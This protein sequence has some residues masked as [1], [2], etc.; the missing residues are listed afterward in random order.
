[1]RDLELLVTL[2]PSFPH[3]PKFARDPRLSGIRLN[4]AMTDSDELI[5]ELE[6]VKLH[7][8]T[9]PLYFDVKGRQL[10][11]TKVHV[12]PNYLDI[13]LNH[14]I[15][16]QTPTPVLFKGGA[17]H[18]LLMNVT[19]N[20]TR[21]IFKQ[22]PQYNVR[23]GE[24]LHIRQDGMQIGGPLFTDAELDKIAKVKQAG[25]KR[26]F[27]SYVEQQSD[28]DQFQELVGRDAEI[29]LKIESKRGLKFVADSF[30]KKDNLVLVAARGDLFVEVDKPHNILAAMKLIINNDS[31]ACVGSR[32]FLSII[33]QPLR[34][35]FKEVRAPEV[36]NCADFHEAA[37]LYDI[38]YR[39]MM[40]CDE[41]CLFEPLLATAVSAFDSFK[42]TYATH[43]QDPP[44]PNLKP[45]ARWNLANL[46]RRFL[47]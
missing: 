30:R 18:A 45:W 47:K 22:G 8:N 40:L 24:S 12:N 6:L 35:E 39:R 41:L 19:E 10:R 4:S 17:D 5:K 44:A 25:F 43:S 28:I 37:W 7:P 2:W 3:F 32:F 21:L 26:Y 27:L 15:K 29:W 20:G 33:P 11:V 38:G 14:P 34:N 9:A 1:M 23:P 31:E 36:P 42:T 16:I 46:T 13:S